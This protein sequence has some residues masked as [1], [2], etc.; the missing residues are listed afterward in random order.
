MS[1]MKLSLRGKSYPSSLSLQL[2]KTI[3]NAE[4][5]N[6]KFDNADLNPASI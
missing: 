3:W 4:D 6:N 1:S 5:Q 2:F